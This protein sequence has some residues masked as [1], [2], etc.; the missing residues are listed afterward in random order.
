MELKTDEY[1]N[2]WY[3]RLAPQRLTDI[4]VQVVCVREDKDDVVFAFEIGALLLEEVETHGCL[5]GTLAPNDT[6]A[7]NLTRWADQLEAYVTIIRS[8]L[9]CR[10]PDPSERSGF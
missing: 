2:Y 5:D 9:R 10:T 3:V 6:M 8:A 4:L 1:G 7:M